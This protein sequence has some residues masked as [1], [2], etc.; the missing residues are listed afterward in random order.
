MIFYYIEDSITGLNIRT[1]YRPDQVKGLARLAGHSG[2]RAISARGAISISF[3]DNGDMQLKGGVCYIPNKTEIV[4]LLNGMTY[5]IFFGASAG[6][7]TMQAGN[8]LDANIIQGQVKMQ[9]VTGTGEP[10][11]SYNFTQRN[12]GE[13]DQFYTNV[14]VNGELWENVD[15]IQDLGFNQKGCVVKTGINGGLD[16][17]FGN[18]DMGAIPPKGSKIVCEYIVTDGYGANISK[19]EANSSKYWKIQGNGMLA[20]GSEIPL[21]KNFTIKCETDV[22]FGTNSEDTAMTQIIAPHVSRSF[23]LANETNYKYFFK[24]MNMFSN[25]QVIRGSYNVNGTSMMQL[26]YEQACDNLKEAQ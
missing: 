9:Y 2:A 19:E 14:Y 10:L 5:T 1:A 3:V 11:Q 16:I 17:Y 24:R 23:V 4:S 26:A 13:V 25:I 12:Y 15:S 21:D 22:I 20:D 6:R 7:I 8:Y 18:K